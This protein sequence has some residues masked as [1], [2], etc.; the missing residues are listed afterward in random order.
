MRESDLVRLFASAPVKVNFAGFIST[1]ADMADHG[2]EMVLEKHYN[3]SHHDIELFTAFRHTKSKA[4][5]KGVVVGVGE[6]RYRIMEI[7]SGRAISMIDAVKAMYINIQF[8]ANDTRFQFIPETMARPTL[9]AVDMRPQIDHFQIDEVALED[10]CPF[11]QVQVSEDFEIYLNQKDEAE[12]LEYVLKRQDPKQ[13]EI[14]KNK[15]RREWLEQGSEGT[16]SRAD[17]RAQLL[18]VS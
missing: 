4:L 11:K 15:R 6:W 17:I 5:L 16:D 7:M 14:R 8:V 9:Q 10:I 18:V 1:T 2:W 13:R 3:I 12:I